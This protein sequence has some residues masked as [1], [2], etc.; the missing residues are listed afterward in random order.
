MNLSWGV[1][2]LIFCMQ[3]ADICINAVFALAMWRL[4][5]VLRLPCRQLQR[6]IHALHE[7]RTKLQASLESCEKRI[8][9]LESALSSSMAQV[10][11]LKSVILSSLPDGHNH[12]ASLP[13]M[14]PLGLS[15][16]GSPSMQPARAAL[17]IAQEL[18]STPGGDISRGDASGAER[19]APPHSM[20]SPSP[21][22]QRAFL[23]CGA[24]QAFLI[25]TA[26][27]HRKA[28]VPRCSCDSSPH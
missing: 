11:T 5:R 27:G 25:L 6:G 24:S 3:H 10:S 1:C 20:P 28:G 23:Q 14:Q 13:G 21:Q 8:T 7:D 22:T 15:Q 12:A 19:A 2:M 26:F 18:A 4:S 9:Q 17:Q 16:Q